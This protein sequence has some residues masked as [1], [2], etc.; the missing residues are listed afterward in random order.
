MNT[1]QTWLIDYTVRLRPWFISGVF[2]TQRPG[3]RDHLFGRKFYQSRDFI[4]PGKSF[5]L[6]PC[7]QEGKLLEGRDGVFRNET[8][9]VVSKIGRHRS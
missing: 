3:T 4:L 7:W 9:L 8:E 6:L 5:H 1:Q 2:P